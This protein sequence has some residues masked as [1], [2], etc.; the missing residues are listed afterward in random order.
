MNFEITN[1]LINTIKPYTENVTI[2][3]STDNKDWKGRNYKS[4]LV[5][6]D[7]KNRV[8]FEVL[9][10]EII[11][12]YFTDH[13]H[14]ED[15]SSDLND[16]DDNYIKR[17]KDFIIHL[18]TE[19]IKYIEIY[20]GKKLAAEKYYFVYSDNTEERIGG[21]WWGLGRHLNPYAQKTENTTI[22]KFDKVSG[23]FHKVNE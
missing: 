5:T 14:F 6:I 10:Q 17:A 12:F 11:V 23:C 21:T 7:E 18:F 13:Y 19:Q 3:I 9:D 20:R 8:G 16:G 2:I 1:E 15:D 22:Y 4:D